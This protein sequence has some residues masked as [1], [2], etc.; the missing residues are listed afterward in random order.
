MRQRLVK[1]YHF[2]RVQN[3]I[4]A[5]KTNIL[6]QKR[7]FVIPL[8]SELNQGQ[9]MDR[10]AKINTTRDWMLYNK[11]GN[12]KGLLYLNLTATSA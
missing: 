7:M 6:K 9:E 10:T 1:Y 12:I 2:K 4:I 5:I 8:S 3:S 11:H